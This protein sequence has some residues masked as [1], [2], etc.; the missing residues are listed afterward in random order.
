MTRPLSEPSQAKDI[1]R[2]AFQIRQLERRPAPDTVPV[3]TDDVIVIQLKIVADDVVMTSGD[4]KFFLAITEDMDAMGLID[5]AAWVSTVSSVG[6]ITVQIHNTT[7][8]VD[9]LSTPLTID[10]SETNSRTAATPMVINPGNADVDWA[11]LIRID[12]DGAGTGAKGLGIDL[13]FSETFGS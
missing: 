5:C 10:Q 13:F 4:G 9:M 2:G 6:G 8:A 12:V 11:D 1:G 7:Q 3:T